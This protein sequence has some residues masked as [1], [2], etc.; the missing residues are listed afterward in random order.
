VVVRDFLIALL[1]G[2]TAFSITIATQFAQGEEANFLP[3]LVFGGIGAAVAVAVEFGKRRGNA[4]E[5]E[6]TTRERDDG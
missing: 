5:F 4:S 1:F 6:P 2:L 3:A